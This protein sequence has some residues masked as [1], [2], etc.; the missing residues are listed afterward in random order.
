MGQ[1]LRIGLH[2]PYFGATYGGGEKYLA[3]TAAALRDAFP[4]DRVELLGSVPADRDRYARQLNVD[5]SGIELGSTNRRVTPVHRALNRVRVLR[6]LRNLVLGSQAT[7]LTARYDLF[8][9]M[10]YA[11]PVRCA[12]PR[13]VVLCQF[14]YELTAPDLLDGYQLVVAQSRYV[15]EW[16]ARRW[17]REAAVV[18]PPVDV[19]AAEPDWSRKERIVLS[20]GR[21]IGQGHTKRQ[22]LMVESFGRLAASGLAGWE[23]HLAGAVH[24][25]AMHRGFLERVQELARGLPVHLHPDATYDE[26]QELYRRASLYW[27]AA[28]HGADAD[29]HPEALEHFG[30]TTAEAMAHGAVPVAIGLGGQPEVVRDG[31][32]GFLW[33]EPAELEARTLQL[34]G[35]DVLRARLG[36]AARASSR[37]FASERFGAAMLRALE[38]V[39]SAGDRRSG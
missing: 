13:G 24:R 16:V 22:D 30:M 5:L 39:L 19:P 36:R 32:D 23:L 2:S 20:V 6:P 37:R 38:P 4:G 14:P 10:A 1:P 12:A 17:G 29:R 27:H 9:S 25:D 8:V 26:V 21:F 3:L 18:S 11:I 34:I 28:G 35:D 7:R 33:R 15:R 31:E